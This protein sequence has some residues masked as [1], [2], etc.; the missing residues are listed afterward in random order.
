[1][2]RSNLSYVIILSLLVISGL[3]LIDAFGHGPGPSLFSR[4]ITVQ[5]EQFS[6]NSISTTQLVIISGKVESRLDKEVKLSP[7]IYVTPKVAIER[8]DDS[9]VID[10]QA[11][12]Y[13][14]NQIFP[15]Y[16]DHSTWYFSVENSL[17]NPLILGPEESVPYEIKLYPRKAGMY[18]VHSYFVS[19]DGAYLGRGQT[20]EVTGDSVPTFEEITQF[21]VP[22]AGGGAALAVLT[23]YSMRGVPAGSMREKAIRICFAIKASYETTWVLGIAFWLAAAST[24]LLT[25]ERT[26]VTSVALTLILAAITSGGYAAALSMRRSQRLFAIATSAATVIF[27]LALVNLQSSHLGVPFVQFSHDALVLSV[28]VFGNAVLVAVISFMAVRE[29]GRPE[30]SCHSSQIPWVLEIEF[31]RRGST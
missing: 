15:P 17:P 31:D 14:L 8:P 12:P 20:V 18:H 24:Y 1:M 4:P 2:A 9:S 21:Y 26:Y 28:A 22:L 13:L 19:S 5:D 11:Y 23:L 3:T 7:Y 30:K 25:L 29:R 6:D 16:R 27:Y 10:L